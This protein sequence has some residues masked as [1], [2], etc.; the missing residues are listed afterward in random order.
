MILFL[1][2]GTVLL[3]LAWL[4]APALADPVRDLVVAAQLDNPAS[5]RKLL[6]AGLSANTIDPV[7]GLPVIQVA[8]REDAQRVVEVLVADQDYDPERTAPNGNT[9]L[10]LAAWKHNQPAVL[11]LLAKG[12]AVNRTGW[13][14]LHYSAAS[15]DVAI[16]AILL[17]RR[18]AIDA[19][20]PSQITP[21]M[22]AAREGHQQVVLQLLRA[23]ANAALR[24]N[25][26]L[27]AS[28]IALRADHDA[29]AAAIDA[30]HGANDRTGTER[31]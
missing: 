12:A 27:T 8:L 7:S 22:I 19:E 10:M 5:V 23:G 9:A 30:F 28:Q 20:S 17:A 29:I 21:L 15:G 1:I 24:N 18:A 11:A 13:C 6:A 26:N 4:A 3:A 14:A 2:R 31:Q 16:T 25:E